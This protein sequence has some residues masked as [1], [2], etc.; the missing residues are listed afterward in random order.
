MRL[1]KLSCARCGWKAPIPV[2]EQIA[3]KFRRMHCRSCWATEE[4]RIP[5]TVEEVIAVGP[6]Q[7]YPHKEQ[8][9]GH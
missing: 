2:D 6:V 7:F 1:Y 4:V 5:F 9:H 3:A 8:K